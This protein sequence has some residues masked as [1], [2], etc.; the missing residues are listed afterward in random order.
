MYVQHT[1][2]GRYHKSQDVV[3]RAGRFRLFALELNLRLG[4]FNFYDFGYAEGR[5]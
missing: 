5:G 4:V 1:A 3:I 2:R